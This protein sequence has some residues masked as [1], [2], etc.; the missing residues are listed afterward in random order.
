MRKY[1]NSL[2][3][4]LFLIEQG[5]WVKGFFKDRIILKIYGMEI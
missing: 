5:L 4:N 3:M 1:I 2:I